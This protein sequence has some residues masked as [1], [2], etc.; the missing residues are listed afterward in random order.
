MMRM[1]GESR[2]KKILGRIG[3]Y[4]AFLILAVIIF[5]PFYWIIATSLKTQTDIYGDNRLIPQHITFENYAYAIEQSDVLRFSLNSLIVSASSMVLTVILSVLAV[6]PLTRM[7]FRGK[8]LFY[9]LL[10]TTQVFPTVV[11]IV[12]LYIVFRRLN[13]YNSL[14]ALALL[15]TATCVPIC[16]VLLM[17][18]FRDVPRELE[19]AALIDGCTRI[20]CLIQ[21]V[22]PVVTP[23]VVSGG[24]YVFLSNWQEYLAASSLIADRNKYTLTQGLTLF[25]TQHSTNWGALMATAV[26]LAVPA[27]ILFF[28]IEDYFIDS[29]AGSV[30]E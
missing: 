24:I 15:Y 3:L 28:M 5:F 20:R 26:I 6:Y 8:R 19:D 27:I 22:L 29:L 25:R 9:A 1:N 12:P 2:L 23:A 10:G 16:I 21:I 18:H 30:K 17:G 14:A 13:M 11:T 7:E 4:A